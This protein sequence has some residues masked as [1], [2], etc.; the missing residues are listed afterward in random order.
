MRVTIR[1]M[2]DELGGW[3]PLRVGSAGAIAPAGGPGADRRGPGR[4]AA[5]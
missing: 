1:S 4:S 3:P 2:V 5:V